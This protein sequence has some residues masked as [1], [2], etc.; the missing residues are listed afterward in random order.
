MSNALWDTIDVSD[1]RELPVVKSRCATEEDVGN[2]RAVFHVPVGDEYEPSSP[3][4]IGLPRPAILIATAQ[5]V[6]AIQ[7][8]EVNGK[9]AVGYRPVDGGNGLCM[10]DE[11]ELLDTP[12]E[13][14]G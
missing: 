14:F 5:P 13:R 4:E 8:E 11:L 2:G 6:F 3:A 1:W 9:I 12:D 10:I 7:A